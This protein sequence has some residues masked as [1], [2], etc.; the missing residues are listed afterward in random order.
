MYAFNLLKGH[1]STQV[2]YYIVP[3]VSRVLVGLVSLPV[4]V[5]MQQQELHPHQGLLKTLSSWATSSVEEVA[6][7][8]PGICIFQ[9]YIGRP[10]VFSLAAEGEKSA[11]D[12]KR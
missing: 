4:R 8:G 9:L 10:V 1:L 7:P 6:S 2:A 11:S 3:L 5:N 12:V